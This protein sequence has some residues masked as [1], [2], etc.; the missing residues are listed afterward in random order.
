M[1]ATQSITVLGGLGSAFC[2][3]ISGLGFGL[4]SVRLLDSSVIGH[5]LDGRRIFMI[6]SRFRF[7]GR[8]EHPPNA[9]ARE[10][11][12]YHRQLKRARQLISVIDR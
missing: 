6:Q 3:I 11:Q 4:S 10:I 12:S 1:R 5:K 2:I 8:D 9:D 7:L